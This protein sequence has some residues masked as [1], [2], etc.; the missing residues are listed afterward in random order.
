VRWIFGAKQGEVSESFPI[1]DKY[2]VA[3]LT[4]IYT[5][6]T[7]SVV[8]ARPIIE[9]I[10]RNQKKGALIAAKIGSAASLDAVASATGQ[11]VSHVDSIQFVSPYVPNFGLEPRVVGYSF[12]KQLVGK[13]VSSPVYGNEGLFVL[14]VDNVSARANYNVDMEQARQTILQ[15]QETI[16][17]R[18]GTDALKKKAKIVDD[19]GKFL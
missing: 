13:A 16:I 14:K 2:V 6:G 1:G 19:R 10:L 17:Q 11:P 4:D 9:P 5:K 7:M 12:D 15:Q 8:K 18:T 3:T